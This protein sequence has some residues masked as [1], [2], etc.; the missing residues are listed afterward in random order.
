MGGFCCHCEFA[1]TVFY[2]NRYMCA[3]CL[4][5]CREMLAAT[6]QQFVLCLPVYELAHLLPLRSCK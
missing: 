3:L 4:L 5:Q 6:L 1:V 2:I